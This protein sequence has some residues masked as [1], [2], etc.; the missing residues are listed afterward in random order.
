MSFKIGR[1]IRWALVLGILIAVVISAGAGWLSEICSDSIAEVGDVAIVRQCRPPQ[2]G[3]LSMLALGGLL[4]ALLL[5]DLSQVSFGGVELRR[6]ITK[7]SAETQAAVERAQ[8]SL[9]QILNTSHSASIAV[10]TVGDTDAIVNALSE[11]L[12]TLGVEI[13]AD[14][15]ATLPVKLR[16]EF[17]LELATAEGVLR[18]IESLQ[19]M[20][21]ERLLGAES[22][23]ELDDSIEELANLPVYIAGS[24]LS[25]TDALAILP[26][27]SADTSRLGN[28]VLQ[29][30]ELRL[31]LS[32][33]PTAQ[34]SMSVV[35]AATA[36]LRDYVSA[37]RS[38]LPSD[39]ESSQTIDAVSL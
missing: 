17:L 24:R 32:N 37:I 7:E 16:S 11:Q 39:F 9:T 12:K 22:Q 10:N 3:D 26:D 30:A 25:A 34:V 23:R 27:L 28:L 20:E 35:Q 14:S 2:I 31:V 6:L 15:K 13:P 8:E 33:E 5:P 4:I 38:T 36:R 1:V 21:R 19:V 29:C 18:Q